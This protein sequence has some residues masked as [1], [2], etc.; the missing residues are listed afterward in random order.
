MKAHHVCLGLILFAIAGC[1]G[2][3]TAPTTQSLPRAYSGTAATG[4][5]LQATVDPKQATISFQN[6]S[7]G[8]NETVPFKADSHD[9]GD[10]ELKDP[11]GNLTD[12][13]EVPDQ[14]LLLSLRKAG[15]S[16]HETA[17]A[18]A[19]PALP[20][21][22]SAVASKSMN[23]FLF[24]TT[25]GGFEVG[26][27]SLDSKGN[28]KEDLYWPSG[29]SLEMIGG[30]PFHNGTFPA[31]STTED[32]SGMFF[33]IVGG[34]EKR[35]YVVGDAHGYLVGGP[36][37][38]YLA[39]EK[40]PSK[41]FDPGNSGTFNMTLYQKL[42]AKTMSGYDEEGGSPSF[43]SGTLVIRP[44]GRITLAS[45][46]GQ[47]LAQGT[48]QP[49]ADQPYLYNPNAVFSLHDPCYGLFVFQVDSTAQIPGF[50]NTPAKQTVFVGFRGKTAMIASFTKYITSNSEGPYDYF[51]GLGER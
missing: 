21:S 36:T 42:G 51:Y 34:N 23:Y 28:L 43:V 7:T 46:Q 10:Y 27:G 1:T 31:S 32:S 20:I 50:P 41:A 14:L 13:Y 44:D 45:S 4:D 6:L 16:L 15:P 9:D 24:Q 47:L 5:F 18:A 30:S 11:N 22:I 37:G 2:H 33:T 26:S 3:V 12:A 49:V 25:A 8:Q 38:S 35:S 48:L 19:I 40:A 17:L 39:I 29:S